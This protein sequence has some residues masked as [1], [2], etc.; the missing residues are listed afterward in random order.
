MELPASGEARPKNSRLFFKGEL[1][2]LKQ[3]V[4]RQ[5]GLA[6]VYSLTLIT[7]GCAAFQNVG[8]HDEFPG[9]PEEKRVVVLWCREIRVSEAREVLDAIQGELLATGICTGGSIS[10][11]GFH[12]WSRTFSRSCTACPGDCRFTGTRI[13]RMTGRCG[14]RTSLMGTWIGKRDPG[15]NQ[16]PIRS[17]NGDLRSRP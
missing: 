4:W 11:R 3:D 1:V 12:Y 15:S 8:S 16:S 2:L 13:C 7:M 6:G 17:F 9:R 5:I 10:R 14:W